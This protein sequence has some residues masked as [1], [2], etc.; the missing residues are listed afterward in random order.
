MKERFCFACDVFMLKTLMER[1]NRP[2]LSALSS[3]GG[4]S[5]GCW[6]QTLHSRGFEGHNAKRQLRQGKLA[7][8]AKRRGFS[9]QVSSCAGCKGKLFT[10]SALI[11]A[12]ALSIL[13][14][15]ICN[16]QGSFSGQDS[17]DVPWFRCQFHQVVVEDLAAL[18]SWFAAAA[19]R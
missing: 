10:P 18:T 19:K 3:S 5:S 6:L 14:R 16:V 15:R 9:E 13:D 7:G 1:S 17:R 2:D 4:A 8:R 12:L 11:T